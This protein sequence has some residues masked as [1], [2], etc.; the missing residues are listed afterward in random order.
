M[1]KIQK[2]R[3]VINVTQRDIE[4]GEPEEPFAC[5]VARAVARAFK[6]KIGYVGVNGDEFEMRRGYVKAPKSVET[7]VNKFD[8]LET[9]APFTFT[10][11]Y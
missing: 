1:K 8:K 5:P 10:L 2:R 11:E 9:V 7:F 4:M 6:K 3:K